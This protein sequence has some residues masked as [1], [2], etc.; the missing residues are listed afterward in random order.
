MGAFNGAY[1]G[2]R[3]HKAER[4]RGI[5]LAEL[6]VAM[7]VTLIAAAIV[8][9]IFVSSTKSVATGAAAHA[10]TGTAST[11]MNELS[12]VIRSGVKNQLSGVEKPP[13]I[14]AKPTSLTMYSLV[15]MD[16]VGVMR[17]VKVELSLNAAGALVEKRFKATL[18]AD[19]SWTFP[20]SSVVLLDRTLPGTILPRSASNPFDLFSY[21]KADGTEVTA[22]TAGLTDTQMADIVAVKVSLA[23]RADT[24]SS[25]TPAKLSNKI[26][27]PNVGTDRTDLP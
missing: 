21:I 23:V 8:M 1:T 15:D 18:S 6:L 25:A 14:V 24:K 7:M 26:G 12:R 22:P 9:G 3:T 13:L 16:A 10:D 4:D 19:G 2:Q 17:P 5:G 20:A 27:M 11:L